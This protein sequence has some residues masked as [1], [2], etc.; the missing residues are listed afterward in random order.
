MKFPQIFKSCLLPLAFLLLMACEKFEP[1]GE[2]FVEIEVE[3]PI[4]PQIILN[5]AADT[6]HTRSDV[7]FSLEVPGH[8]WKDFGYRLYLGNELLEER[9]Y[10]QKSIF[11]TSNNRQDGHYKLRLELFEKSN[12]GSLAD[13]VG[14]EFFIYTYDWVLKIDNRPSSSYPIDQFKVSVEEGRLKLSW[15]EYDMPNFHSYSIFRREIGGEGRFK[16][17]YIEDPKETHYYDDD[18]VGGSFTYIMSVHLNESPSYISASPQSLQRPFPSLLEQEQGEDAFDISWSSCLFPKNFEAYEI[19]Q[20][21]KLGWEIVFRTTNIE[22]TTA[23]LPAKFGT[24]GY[25]LHTKAKEVLEEMGGPADDFT[26]SYGVSHNLTFVPAFLVDE[27][28]YLLK[29][30]NG[31][32]VKYDGATLEPLL[33]RR[34]E[35]FTLTISDNG[36]YIYS[37]IGTHVIRINPVTF[38]EEERVSVASLT[39]PGDAVANIAVNNQNQ[40]LLAGI[41]NFHGQTDSMILVDMNN[42]EILVR[43]K[44]PVSYGGTLSNDGHFYLQGETTLIDLYHGQRTVLEE[45]AIWLPHGE[46]RL[47]YANWE[48]IVVLDP[49]NRKVLKKIPT[50]GRLYSLKVDPL[51]GYVGGVLHRGE[52]YI[53]QIYNVET[54]ALIKEIEVNT[55]YI[56]FQNNTLFTTDSYLPLSFQ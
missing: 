44:F 10:L 40:L 20:Y 42:K 36:K 11:F 53:Y 43:K 17:I 39:R 6:L 45:L 25:R 15:P 16:T 38:E 51:T 49:E 14:M 50:P 13:K 5:P 3:E 26:L 48:D 33:S 28:A 21:G 27:N 8:D 52:Q 55:A 4:V 37:S 47:V 23:V 18:F 7:Y 12:T 32:L 30:D 35:G 54:A 22:D 1:E 2:H 19:Y 24:M 34:Y 31:Q 41:Y 9:P 46:P 29:N 56:F